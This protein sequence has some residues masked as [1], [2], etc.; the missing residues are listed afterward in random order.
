MQREYTPLA[1]ST[2][3]EQVLRRRPGDRVGNGRN[4]PFSGVGAEQRATAP[5]VS[6]RSPT[7]THL[8]HGTEV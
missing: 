2:D 3:L 4:P 6:A 1:D 8:W 5:V 7:W